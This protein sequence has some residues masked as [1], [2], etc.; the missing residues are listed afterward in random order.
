MLEG[1][2]RLIP[3]RH[4]HIININTLDRIAPI[5]SHRTIRK[6]VVKIAT[7]KQLLTAT[8]IK[9]VLTLYTTPRGPVQEVMVVG[10]VLKDPPILLV[11][12]ITLVAEQRAP[13]VVAMV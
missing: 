4:L 9:A 10:Q 8:Q 2:M 12:G 7:Q 13:A 5:M 6:T 3:A 1:N 11:A